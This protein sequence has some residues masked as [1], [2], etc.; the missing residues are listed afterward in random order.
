MKE[1]NLQAMFDP[2]SIA[3]IG[4]SRREDTVGY[5]VLH[6]LINHGF[7]GKIYPVNPKAEELEGLKCY[8]SITEISDDVELAV[9][10]VGSKIVPSV[11]QECAEKGV[12]SVI[13]IS[14][15][16]KEIG[17]AGRAIE[18]EVA[19]IAKKHNIS[20]LGPNCLGIINTDPDVAMN[21]SF[22]RVMPSVGTIAFISQSGA[23]CTA[24]L[25]Y[26]LEK[27][28]GFSKFISL[29]N[30]ADVTEGD[31]LHY[32]KDDIYTDVILMYLE[33]IVDG[34]EF[35]AHAREIV[36]KEKPVLA[37]KAG[38]TAE[39]AKAASS[40][41]GSMMGSDE[42]YDAIFTQ[43]GVMRVDSVA[44]IF[45]F[46]V[47]F[48]NQPLPKSN[49]V[50]IITNAGGPGIMATDAC[51]KEGLEMAE[52][53]EDTTKALKKALP[54]TANFSNPVDV[55][56]DA[57]HD[58]Y[59]SVL[60]Q[61]VKDENVDGIIVI[62]TPQAMT[63]IHEIANV[64]VKYSKETDKTILSCFMGGT[65]VARGITILEK[66]GVPHYTFPH[67]VARALAAMS[68]YNESLQR[69]YVDT[70]RYDV[71]TKTAKEIF[72]KAKEKGQEFLTIDQ[73]MDVFKAYGLPLLPYGMAKDADEAANIANEIG[74]PVV[75]KV[76]AQEIVHKI[77]VGGV[78]LNIADEE[79]L[80][81]T[82]SAMLEDIA[83]ASPEAVIDGVF[84]Q[85]M[86][87]KGKEVILG[88]KRDEQFGPVL[89]FGLGGIYVE[90]IKD[91]TFGLAPL[92]DDDAKR[93]IHT[94]KTFPLLEGLRGEK[95]SDIENIKEGLK[96]L[97]QLSCDNEEIKEIDINPL[98]VYEEGEGTK[99]L[100]A[101]IIL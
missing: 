5:A 47:A 93:M 70:K 76:V 9:I 35:I 51:V 95:P 86:G 50:A 87:K 61:L 12:K 14:A 63:D 41:T 58:R 45:N 31:L 33:D 54:A 99:V 26:A 82:Y 19:A 49:R 16:F 53:S 66:N 42:V 21:A 90:V 39:G 88:M 23:L 25:D 98:L 32:L 83:K 44:D 37:I 67:D 55:I 80:R 74:Y 7:V 78:R 3:V 92:Q 97:S 18:D 2:M 62:L 38:R 24:I 81:K 29:G 6:N 75:L 64:I 22:S 34:E 56:G 27:N 48:A 52:F 43:S 13:V 96:R 40:H 72:A 36:G 15:G 11:M 4:A 100:D 8:P 94:I 84:V 65:D 60:E 71:D 85:A 46:A 89:M 79:D 10:I 91:V 69:K 59:E 30:K 101:R 68:Q 1:K 77:D 20:L 17:E 57:K 73:S 28:I